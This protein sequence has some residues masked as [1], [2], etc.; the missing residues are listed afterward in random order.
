M[1]EPFPQLTSAR[2][3]KKQLETLIFL[4]CYLNRTDSF[5]FYCNLTKSFCNEAF[6]E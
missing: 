1:T 5:H 6:A 2:L 4:I 3:I